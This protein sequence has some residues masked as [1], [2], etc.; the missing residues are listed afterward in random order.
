MGRKVNRTREDVH[1]NGVAPSVSML[2]TETALELHWSRSWT[3]SGVSSQAAM[4]SRVV[5]LIESRGVLRVKRVM[6]G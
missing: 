2:S 5:S 1:I 3:T 6:L 4:P